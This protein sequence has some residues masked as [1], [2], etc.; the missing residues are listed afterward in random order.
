MAL[1]E[2]DVISIA[3]LARIAVE[4][5]KL[6]EY[7]NN[8]ANILHLAEQMDSVDISN[9]EPMAHPLNAKQRLRSD[10]VTESDEHKKFQSI[11]PAVENGLYIVPK[12]ID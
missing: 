7:A 6:S 12:V 1:G 10:N 9:V 8:L 3:H 4:K 11:A 5:E 2:E